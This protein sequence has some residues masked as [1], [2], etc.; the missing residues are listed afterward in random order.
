MSLSYLS[1]IACYEPSRALGLAGFWSPF[2]QQKKGSLRQGCM[3]LQEN[4]RCLSITAVQD[5][6]LKAFRQHNP[7]IPHDN[8]GSLHSG[9]TVSASLLLRSFRYDMRSL[10]SCLLAVYCLPA[11][12]AVA[13]G[14]IMMF[15][16]TPFF[17]DTFRSRRSLFPCIPH[18]Y[19]RAHH[20]INDSDEPKKTV[21]PVSMPAR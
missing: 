13:L 3:H 6:R 11:F 18:L 4:N 19:W 12:E 20:T 1:F 16:L 14:P 9:S 15:P 8:I 7:S 10:T 5:R 2:R 21:R 17:S